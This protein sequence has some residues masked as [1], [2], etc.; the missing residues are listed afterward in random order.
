M[1][2]I[3]TPIIA[4]LSI[5]LSG[6]SGSETY[7]GQWKAMDAAGEKSDITFSAKSFTVRYGKGKI[8]TFEYKQNAVSIENS[9]ETYG[10][11]LKDGRTYEIN[12]P[13]A[14]DESTG[15]IK[16]GS[17]NPLY[18]I[19]RKDYVKYEDIFKLK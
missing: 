18:T 19:G 16:D 15:L 5:A 8:D 1:K 7:R 11:R 4:I 9:V 2:K 12:F 10:I 17:G 14:D 13:I 3:I 6:C